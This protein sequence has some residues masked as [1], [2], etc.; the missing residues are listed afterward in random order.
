MKKYSENCRKGDNIYIGEK[1]ST[2][3]KYII[4]GLQKM[5][6]NM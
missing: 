1:R 3:I 4:V 5:T 6:D 2:A